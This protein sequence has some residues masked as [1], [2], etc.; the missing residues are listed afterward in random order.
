[1]RVLCRPQGFCRVWALNVKGSDWVNTATI[2]LPVW[3]HMF[4]QYFKCLLFGSM[5]C[6][7]IYVNQ[8]ISQ[9]AKHIF[10]SINYCIITIIYDNNLTI[11]WHQIENKK[12]KQKACWSSVLCKQEKWRESLSVLPINPVSP[13]AYV[14]K[15]HRTWSEASTVNNK[16]S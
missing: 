15:H 12:R 6:S 10:I 4:L 7:V 3:C 9:N 13:S 8:C 11:K 5:L 14:N 16:L 2:Y 1:M